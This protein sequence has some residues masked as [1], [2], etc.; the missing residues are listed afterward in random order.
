[1]QDT[2]KFKQV[3]CPKIVWSALNEYK[4]VVFVKS[5]VGRK[6]ATVVD[7]E[8]G[9]AGSKVISDYCGKNALNRTKEMTEFFIKSCADLRRCVDWEFGISRLKIKGRPST[10]KFL[11]IYDFLQKSLKEKISNIEKKACF[12]DNMT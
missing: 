8:I 3:R 2:F 1:V 5:K 11:E 10:K 6:A 12:S 4:K 9:Q 7:C